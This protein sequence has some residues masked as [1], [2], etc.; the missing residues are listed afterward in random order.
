MSTKSLFAKAL[1]LAAPWEVTEVAF[2]PEENRLDIT[3][4]FRRGST[5]TCPVCGTPGAKPYDTK[6]EEWRHLNFFQ[7][8]TYLETYLKNC[9]SPRSVVQ[10]HTSGRT[11]GVVH[12]SL[13]GWW[14]RAF[15]TT[16]P[17]G[18]PPG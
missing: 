12:S 15:S 3:I 7:Y 6:E 18:S 1:G 11:V 4:D 10:V 9:V 14:V 5:F 17:V 2:S 16:D 13:R 8:T